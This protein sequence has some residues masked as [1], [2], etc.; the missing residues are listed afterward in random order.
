MVVK[1]HFSSKPAAQVIAGIAAAI[2]SALISWSKYARYE[3]N[4]AQHEVAYIKFGE[5]AQVLMPETR[6]R[7]P[8]ERSSAAAA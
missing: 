4:A 6:I 5:V 1:T 8:A 2:V 3:T 7:A